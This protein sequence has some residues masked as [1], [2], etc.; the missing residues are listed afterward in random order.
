MGL[1]TMPEKI[2]GLYNEDWAHGTHLKFRYH[3]RAA[4]SA[5]L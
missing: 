4:E 2:S 3:L 1:E 5:L